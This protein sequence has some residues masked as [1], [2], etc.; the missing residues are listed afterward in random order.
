MPDDITPARCVTSFMLC[1][2][3]WWFASWPFNFFYKISNQ[4]FSKCFFCLFNDTSLQM[5]RGVM[6]CLVIGTNLFKTFN[7]IIICPIMIS[8]YIVIQ[9]FITIFSNNSLSLLEKLESR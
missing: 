6:K 8:V 4:F 3:T 2:V 1:D 5:W 7:K 9:S